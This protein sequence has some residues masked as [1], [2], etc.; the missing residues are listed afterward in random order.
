MIPKKYTQFSRDNPF[1]ISQWK[2]KSRPK[3]SQI[4]KKQSI[5][6]LTIFM[7]DAIYCTGPPVYV[8]DTVVVQERHHAPPHH[9]H[10]HNGVILAI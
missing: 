1:K 10:H 3:D 9:H 6:Q 2:V 7:Y 4:D 8:H 5:E